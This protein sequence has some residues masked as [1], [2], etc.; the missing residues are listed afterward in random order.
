M[1]LADELS[2][3]LGAAPLDQVRARP[4]V[5]SFGRIRRVGDGVATASGLLDVGVNERVTLGDG[6]AGMAT[7]LDEDEVGIVLLGPDDTLGAGDRV[8]GSGEVVR[9]PVGDALLGRVIDP[10]GIP[11]DGGPVP[12]CEEALPID[13]DAPPI[14]DRALVETPVHTG[15][16]VIDAMIPL[17]RGQRQ[18]VIGDRKTGKTALALD[19][20]LAQ[21]DPNVRWVWCSIGQKA[22][23][24]SMV[25]QTL[26]DRA[27]GCEGVVVVGAA[28]APPGLQWLAPFAASSVAEHFRDAGHDVL[29]VFDDLTT[30][31]AVH[32]ELGLLLRDPPGREAYPADVFHV[33]ARLLERATRLAPERGGG[34]VTA[35]AVAETHAG[36]LTA[37]IPTNL[38]S[39]TDGQLYLEPRLFNEGH[40]PAVDVGLSVSRVGGRTQPKVLRKL[41]SRLKLAYAQFQELEVFTRF[42][43]TVDER[44]R[45]TIAHGR[46][47]RAALLQSRNDPRS[48]A[49]EVAVLL[50][51]TE[52]LLDDIPDDRVN[53]SL[54][55]ARA[56]GRAR[57]AA[58]EGLA[59]DADLPDDRRRELLDALRA[60]L[61]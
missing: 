30:H 12:A 22:S 17:G 9:V 54:E 32:R 13:R 56:V 33:H 47:I 7:A 8:V 39:I 45:R 27:G 25:V 58:I 43:S 19:A 26:R 21:R 50:A 34:S 42:G 57:D 41:S 48:L 20:V 46:R 61:G 38:V 23:T 40:R 59:H 29:L 37:Y 52:G 55:E 10:L 53:A 36:N 3:W 60:A 6:V 11:L 16:L 31:A 24:V 18:L 49:E 44:T 51:L 5:R 14:A 15:L 2:A 4:R 1:P 35:L 28:D